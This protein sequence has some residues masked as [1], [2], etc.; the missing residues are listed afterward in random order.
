MTGRRGSVAVTRR[1]ATVTSDAT[2]IVESDVCHLD[3]LSDIA[4]EVDHS[5]LTCPSWKNGTHR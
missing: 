5:I 1:G 2:G 3:R 4:G